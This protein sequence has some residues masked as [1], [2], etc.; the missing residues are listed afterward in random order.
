MNV[1]LK[2]AS[3]LFIIHEA[4]NVISHYNVMFTLACMGH[5]ARRIAA[6]GVVLSCF[7][8]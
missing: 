4:W 3:L 6:Q 5:V 1:V 7:K 8:D 2:C